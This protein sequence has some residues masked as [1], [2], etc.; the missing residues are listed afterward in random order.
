MKKLLVISWIFFMS[1]V[2]CSNSI[3]TGSSHEEEKVMMQTKSILASDQ[4]SNYG[5]S[6]PWIDGSNGGT[7]FGPWAIMINAGTGSAGNFIGDPAT[8]GISGMSTESFALYANPDASGALV[9]AVRP[10]SSPLSVGGT[11]SFQWGVNWD[12]NGSGEK[13]IVLMSG[14]TTLVTIKM[15]G[16][17]TITINGSNMFLN[18]GTDAMTI[19]FELVSLTE[20]RVYATGRD[21]SEVYDNTFTFGDTIAPDRVAFYAQFLASGEQRQPYFDK[22]EITSGALPVENRSNALVF[23]GTDDYVTVPHDSSLNF[24]EFTVEMWINKAETKTTKLIGK[25]LSSSHE[26]G[27]V[28][29]ITDQDLLF[30]ETWNNGSTFTQGTSTMTIPNN[31][32]IHLAM[33]WKSGD[34]LKGYINGQTVIDVATASYDIT[35][36]NALIIGMAPWND[37]NENHFNGKIDEIRIWN[38]IRTESEIR[39]NMYRELPDPVSETNLAAYYKFNETAGTVL[40]DSKNSNDGTLTNMSGSEWQASPAMSGPKNALDFD[41][42]NDYVYADLNSS[43]STAITIESYLYFNDLTD[44][45]NII[46]IDDGGIN[47]RIISYKSADNKINLFVSNSSNQNDVLNSDF[48]LEAYKWYHLAFVYDNKNVSIYVDGKKVAEKIMTY[49]YALDGTDRLY[50]GADWGIGF[51]SN[52]KMDEVRIWNTARTASEIRENMMRNLTGNETGLL[53]YYNFDNTSGT[54]LQDFSGNGN[55]GTLTNMDDSDWV[56]SEA[57]DTWLGAVDNSWSNALNWSDGVPVSSDNIGIYKWTGGSEVSIS[58]APEINNVV[59]SVTASPVLSSDITVDGNFINAG[60][61]IDTG[62]ATVFLGG[63]AQ[64]VAGDTSFYNLFKTVSSADTLSFEHGST[65]T[66][67]GTL[68]L[69]GAAGQELSLRSDL[70]GNRWK[71]NPQSSRDID[72][73][74]VKDSENINANLIN[75]HHFTDS[76]NNIN[77]MLSSYTLTY[78]AGTGGSITGTSPQTVNYGSDGTEITAVPD[79]GYSFVKWSDDVLTSSRTDTNVTADI[80]VSAEFADI[81]E[82][83][84]AN[85]GCAQNCNNTAGSY[86]CSCNSGYTLNVDGKACDDVNECLTENGGCAQNCNNTAGSYSC[87]C[88]SGYTLN[89][90]GKACDDVNE[91]DTAN[92]GCAQTCNNT[93]GSYNCSCDS[94]YTLNVDGKACDDV[95]E[96][97]TANGGCAQTCNNTAG[98]YNCT[99]DSGYTLN[100]DGKACDDIN[101]CDTANGGCAQTCNNTAGSYN[102]TCDSGYTLNVD[103]KA[104]DDIN[105]CDTANGGCAQTCNNTA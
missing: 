26:K 84:T 19:H 54:T 29:G 51:I 61:T 58:G 79:A 76:G 33:T 71:I 45:Q 39:Q 14:V 35:T 82:C 55:D 27:F 12:S 43:G 52:V 81:N 75:V 42:V 21:G 105:E 10:F 44:Q 41:G 13:G 23:D 63:T 46:H 62:I 25:S 15:G 88:D 97:D 80:T 48:T 3:D 17:G 36:T 98:S 59:I 40:E 4:G 91:C 74:N 78:T 87:S 9:D 104:C 73:V 86:S 65:T 100:V 18:Y 64:T 34:R 22:L 56:D 96:C 72:Y 92:G 50:L 38:D 85:G 89:V 47:Q 69:K 94:G 67:T 60:G 57:F 16:S 49:S 37:L 31:Q 32:W 66:V 77:W 95:N 68:T 20:L 101:E 53:A 102:C 30:I 24:T 28:V 5:V 11:F 70:S 99:C 6:N 103:G 1:F 7:G 90:D 2:S 83:D 8:A 93:A